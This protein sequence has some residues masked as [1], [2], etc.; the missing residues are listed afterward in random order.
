MEDTF[1]VSLAVSETTLY[2]QNTFIST[3]SRK[4]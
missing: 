1:S 3:H 4:H 2:E